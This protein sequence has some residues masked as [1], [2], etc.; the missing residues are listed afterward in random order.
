M[1]DLH[2]ILWVIPGVIFISIYNR[3]RPEMAINLSGWPYIFFVVVLAAITWLPAELILHF[4]I[5]SSKSFFIKKLCINESIVTLLIAILFS[6][7]WLICTQWKRIAEL[8][9]PPVY[10]NFYRKCTEWHKKAI[11]LTLKNGKAYIGILWKYSE[12]P[13]SRYESQT[14]SITPLRSGYREKEQ[15]RIV[16]TT[17]YPHNE[18]YFNNMELILPRSEIL[19]F[20]KFNIEAHKYFEDL[21]GKVNTK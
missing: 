7:F 9:F 17:N 11:L 5:W 20:G 12:H 21:K 16:W 1:W 18:S 13:K 10:D 6:F 2:G 3:R 8:V 4:N 19:T 14:I 15:K